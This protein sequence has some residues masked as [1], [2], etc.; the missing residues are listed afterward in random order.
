MDK[1]SRK[2]RIIDLLILINYS[3]IIFKTSIQTPYLLDT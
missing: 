2:F 3:D 1:A